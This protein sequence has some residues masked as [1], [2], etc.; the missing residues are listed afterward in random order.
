MGSVYFQQVAEVESPAE[1]SKPEQTLKMISYDAETLR[2][3]SFP[4]LVSRAA[5]GAKQGL[6]KER[7]A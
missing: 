1:K 4:V 5:D 3:T 2:I 7:S 6:N